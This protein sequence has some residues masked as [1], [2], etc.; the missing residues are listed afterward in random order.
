MK[1]SFLYLLVIM[2][3]AT[4]NV[5]AQ[6]TSGR[7]KETERL[8]S[9]KKSIA[10]TDTFYLSE[11]NGD[12]IS[13]RR[14]SFMYKAAFNKKKLELSDR[15]YDVL[16]DNDKT[17][18]LRDEEG[19]VSIFTPDGI[20]PSSA[21]I[22]QS[23]RANELPTATLTNV[24]ASHISGKWTAY[25]RG[26]RDGKPMENIDYNTIIKTIVVNSNADGD[27]NWGNAYSNAQGEGDPLYTIASISSGIVT[28]KNTDGATHTLNIVVANEKE[29]IAE[30][31]D[32][33]VYYFRK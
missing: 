24:D 14:G 7:W 29:W 20:N 23:M 22:S 6:N 27:G 30:G 16:E 26:T 31:S 18:K 5:N 3:I 17:I 21:A 12:N 15:M 2:F 10:Y 32:K 19:I 1:Y 4:T 33:V 13:M 8:D 25:K 9:K 11:R 28:L